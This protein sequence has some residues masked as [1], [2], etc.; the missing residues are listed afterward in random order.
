[1]T[2]KEIIAAAKTNWLAWKGL[3]ELQPEV[4]AWMEG[5]KADC[6][7]IEDCSARVLSFEV[8]TYMAGRT[9]RLRPDYEPMKWWFHPRDLS[10]MRGVEVA[11]G[12]ERPDHSPGWLEVTAEYAA[13]LHTP[14]DGYP[15][16]RVPEAGDKYAGFHS[17]NQDCYAPLPDLGSYDRGYR[18]CKTKAPA[19]GWREYRVEARNNVYYVK[20]YRGGDMALHKALCRVGFGGVQFAGHDTWCTLVAAYEDDGRIMTP[21][22]ARFWTEAQQ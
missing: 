6:R 9:Y 4:A 1:M 7:V 15:E 2:E 14:V 18:W 22:K 5:H 19:Y 21:I 11:N 17:L 8:A 20:G 12:C 3:N 10:M 13:Y 16:L